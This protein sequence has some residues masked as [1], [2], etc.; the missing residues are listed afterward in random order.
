MITVLYQR[1]AIQKFGRFRLI[2][3]IVKPVV[4]YT[5]F[6]DDAASE[7]RDFPWLDFIIK[8]YYDNTCRYFVHWFLKIRIRFFNRVGFLYF[9]FV[10][11]SNEKSFKCFK[12]VGLVI[13][14][15]FFFGVLFSLFQLYL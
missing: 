9:E 10:Y 5:N 8:G 2:V 4:F 11:I 7:L 1:I 3:M 6:V 14:Y 12:I 13:F 15:W